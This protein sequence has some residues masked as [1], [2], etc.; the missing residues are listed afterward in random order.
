MTDLRHWSDYLRRGIRARLGICGQSQVTLPFLDDDFL[1]AEHTVIPK[2]AMSDA[3][4][5]KC[6][7]VWI[8][9]GLDGD[10]PLVALIELALRGG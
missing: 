1:G 2:E 3:A 7:I 5:D 4:D 6:V 8:I 10:R 9:G